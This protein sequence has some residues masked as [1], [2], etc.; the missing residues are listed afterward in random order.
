MA[1]LMAFML[2]IVW[3]CCSEYVCMESEC[4]TEEVIVVVVPV[5]IMYMMW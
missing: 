5:I 4:E 3:L 2:E 1:K